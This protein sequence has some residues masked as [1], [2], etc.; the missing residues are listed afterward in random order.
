M[1]SGCE[2]KIMITIPTSIFRFGLL[3][4]C[5]VVPAALSSLELLC[6]QVRMSVQLS[7]Y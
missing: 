4:K 5:I 2:S 6:D 1:S 3:G 7:K